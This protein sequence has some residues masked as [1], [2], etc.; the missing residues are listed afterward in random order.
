LAGMKTVVAELFGGMD[1]EIIRKDLDPAIR[2]RAV[3]QFSP[4]EAVGFVFFLK[5][6]VRDLLHKKYPQLLTDPETLP[7]VLDLESKIDEIG[8]IAVDIYVGC[9]E[10]IFDLKAKVERNTVYKAFHRAGLIVEDPEDGP[11]I[12]PV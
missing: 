2:I 8:L 5:T 10:K 9:R 7:A 1:H 4:S 11:H 12:R 6:I 3:Q